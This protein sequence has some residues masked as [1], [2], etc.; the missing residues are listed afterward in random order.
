[1]CLCK[2]KDIF[3][4][5]K[6]GIHN[7]RFMDFAIVDIIFTI[8]GAYII[9]KYTQYD[10]YKVL[11]SLFILGIILHKLFCVDTKLNSIIFNQ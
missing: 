1:M 10:F 9:Y 2:Y 4:K 3:G 11:I 5:P 8:L 7:Y 6:E